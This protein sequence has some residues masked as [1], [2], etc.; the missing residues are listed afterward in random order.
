MRA[1]RNEERAKEVQKELKTGEL[2]ISG[3]ENELPSKEA[4]L[5]SKGGTLV[6]YIFCHLNLKSKLDNG[7]G[8]MWERLGKGASSEWGRRS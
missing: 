2:I 6:I 7:G 8:G 3:A 4:F 1:C 5:A